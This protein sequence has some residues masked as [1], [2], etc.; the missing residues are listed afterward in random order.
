MGRE[1]GTALGSLLSWSLAEGF[2]R[3][4]V[5]QVGKLAH[6]TSVEKS[7]GDPLVSRGK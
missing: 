7:T 4:S 6:G 3:L 1:E 5:G 2:Q